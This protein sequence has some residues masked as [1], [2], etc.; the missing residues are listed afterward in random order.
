MSEKSSPIHSVKV[1]RVRAAIWEN[2]SENGAWHSVTFSRLYKDDSGAWKDS[3]S[4]SRDDLP[5]LMKVA[6]QV[7]TF[8]FQKNPEQ[9]AEIS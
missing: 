6:D 7:H 4:F 9:E 1:G 8:L 2:T 5:L 3:S